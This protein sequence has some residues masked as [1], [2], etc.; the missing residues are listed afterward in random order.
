MPE[1]PTNYKYGGGANESLL[2]PVIAILM[3]LAI[4][5]IFVLPRKYVTLPLLWIVMLVP[6]SQQIFVAGVHLYVLRIVILCGIVRMF[7]SPKGPGRKL[8]PG[9]MNGIDVAF[10]VCI[11]AQAVSVVLLFHVG[12]AVINQISFIWDWVGG[13]FVIRWALQD[14]GDVYR[15][16]KYLAV[17]LV[18]VAIVM[19]IEQLKM[20]NLFSL[21]GGVP[22]VPEVRFGKI[23]A[24]G[25]FEHPIIAGTIS[26]VIV[27][28]FFLLW[29]NGKSKFLSALGVISA[30]VMMWTAN[31][32]TCLFA[33]GAGL[34][35]LLIWPLR[36]SMKQLRWG[37]ALGLIGLDLVM[38][39]PIWF[40]IARVDL[41]GGSSSYHRAELIN[42]FV[43]HFSDWWLI[44]VSNSASW[45]LD[46]WDVQNQYVNIGEAGGLVAFVFFIFLL[47]RAFGR[48]G[49][50]R[51]I[52]DGDKQREWTLWCL[53]S[54]LF[55][56]V[57]AFF[58]VNYFDQSRMLWFLSLAMISAVTA[59]LPQLQQAKSPEVKAV[60]RNDQFP[61]AAPQ[62]APSLAPKPFS[63]TKARQLARPGQPV[64]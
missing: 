5:C 3:L 41:T 53:G 55:A 56:N 2:H 23:R 1:M 24:S 61:L 27:P 47:S 58:G 18:P 21:L 28:L 60:P 54:A 26:A 10:T 6:V 34:G 52:V 44:G 16:L 17:L 15:S 48:I 8:F 36:K 59:S 20:F 40:L 9:G 11:L 63:P 42:E 30:T 4:V 37:I 33:Y 49:D 29:K 45:G 46:M 7:A 22:A 12:Q 38:R 14:E 19:S 32:S 62:P 43:N 13:Y 64:R 31:S 51:K 25:V 50:A 39:A 57:I 35:A